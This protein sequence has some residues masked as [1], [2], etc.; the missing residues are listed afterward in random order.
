MLRKRLRVKQHELL[1]K[2]LKT[3][4]FNFF[5]VSNSVKN[6]CQKTSVLS[7]CDRLLCLTKEM[8]SQP[9]FIFY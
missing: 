5:N 9:P 2:L 7:K 8:S 4:F 3:M 6:P 1:L